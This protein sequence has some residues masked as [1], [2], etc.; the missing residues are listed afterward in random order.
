[1]ASQCIPHSLVVSRCIPHSLMASRCIPYSLM[2]SQFCVLLTVPHSLM[3]SLLGG[4]A[5]HCM[6]MSSVYYLLIV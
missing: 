6:F 5:V 2:A 1:M 3:A 4:M